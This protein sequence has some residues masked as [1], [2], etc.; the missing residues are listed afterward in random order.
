MAEQQNGNL[1]L[2]NQTI[3]M[4][5]AILL[6]GSGLGGV[7]G[8]ATNNGV[9]KQELQEVLIAL[10]KVDSAKDEV[11]SV[12]RDAS[13]KRLTAIEHSIEALNIK[14]DSI[15]DCCTARK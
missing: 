2:N 5:L 3:L 8:S 7:V 12:R 6:G 15:K 1:K 4:L 13:D 11:D 14:V 10:D 9:S